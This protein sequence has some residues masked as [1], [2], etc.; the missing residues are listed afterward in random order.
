FIPMTPRL[1]KVIGILMIAVITVINV[2]G[3][4]ESA[5]VQNVTTM[6]KVGAILLMGAAL[7]LMGHNFST[8]VAH[9]QVLTTSALVTG[10]GV[11]MISVLWAYEGWTYTTFVAGETIDPKRN[12]AGGLI[13]GTAALIVIYVFANFGYIAAL[14]ADGVSA[15][16]RVAATSVSTV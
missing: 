10:F 6:I 15:S 9:P 8:P 12:F 1:A 3:T 4:R 7:L 13:V 5:D 14:G 11:A 16:D 2:W